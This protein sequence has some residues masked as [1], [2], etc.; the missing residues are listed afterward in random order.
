ML[1]KSALN[2]I[3][4]LEKQRNASIETIAPGLS[5]FLMDSIDIASPSGV[6][7]VIKKLDDMIAGVA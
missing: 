7:L 3:A 1:S 5:D 6:L 2:L 4:H